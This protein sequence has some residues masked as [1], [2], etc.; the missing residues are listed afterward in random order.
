MTNKFV[1]WGVATM[2]HPGERVSGDR[3]LMQ[4]HAGG[5]LIAGVDGVGHG[6]EAARVAEAVVDVLSA[7]AAQP[8]DLLLGHCHDALIGTRGAVALVLAYSASER[9]LGWTGLGHVIGAVIRVDPLAR[10]ARELLLPLPGV[11]GLARAAR[12]QGFLTVSPGDLLVLATDGIRSEFVE[13]VRP[14]ED[15]V[16]LAGRLLTSHCKGTDDALVLAARFRG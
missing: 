12:H 4:S 16:A 6:P 8:L 11:L 5:L 13:T 1:D 10:P 7:H 14:A 15:P 9:V 2:P 3:C